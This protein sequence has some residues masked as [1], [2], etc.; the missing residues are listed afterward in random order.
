MYVLSWQHSKS[1]S[2]W[3]AAD[4]AA[5]HCAPRRVLTLVGSRLTSHDINLKVPISNIII[6]KF[7]S[8]ISRLKST[9]DHAGRTPKFAATHRPTKSWKDALRVQRR[10]GRRRMGRLSQ[11]PSR[12][13]TTRPIV[14]FTSHVG[15]TTEKERKAREK[16]ESIRGNGD[17]DWTDV[18]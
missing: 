17:I 18:E 2:V 1:F 11:Q 13:R 7:H 12:C 4:R 9:S 6:L 3:P 10:D 16:E 14:R 5:L 8:D 15:A